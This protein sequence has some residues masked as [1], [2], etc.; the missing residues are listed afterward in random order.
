MPA[1][2]RKRFASGRRVQSTIARHHIMTHLSSPVS[3]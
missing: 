1:S 3:D 2:L